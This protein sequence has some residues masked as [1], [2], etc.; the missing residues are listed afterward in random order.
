SISAYRSFPPGRSYDES[1]PLADDD[2]GYGPQKARS[3]EALEAALPGRVARV[4]PG[5]VVGPWDPT[6]RFTYWPRRVARGGDVLAPGRP[7]R[8]V[9][10][11]DVRDL[12]EWC[13]RLAEARLTGA[14]NV[15]G[16][17]PALTMGELLAECRVVTGS[18]A[19]L[20]WISDER[21]VE[22]GVTRWTE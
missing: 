7:D 1:A 4:R 8:R 16:P 6:D 20:H 17:A 9:S 15:A 11:I 22:A 18:D 14:F 19:R 21:L 3:E 12:A 5:L 10:F 2:D 13:V